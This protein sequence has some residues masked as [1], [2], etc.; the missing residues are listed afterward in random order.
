M[1]VIRNLIDAVLSQEDENLVIQKTEAKMD[2]GLEKI[3]REV[4]RKTD[5]E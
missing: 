2:A 4:E 1:V 5:D 3:L